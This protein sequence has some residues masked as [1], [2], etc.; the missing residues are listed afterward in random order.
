MK[1]NEAQKQI[2][3]GSLLGDAGIN[4]D[5]RYEGYEFAE[6]HS[7]KQ[8]NYLKWKNQ[9]LNFNFKTYEKHNLCTIR[10]SNKIFKDYKDLFYRNGSKIVTKEVLDKLTPLSIA[11]WHM[12]DGDY[13]YKTETIRLATHCF[14]LKGNKLIRNWFIKKWN[15]MPK[16]RRSYNEATKREYFLLEFTC[17]NAKKFIEL[18]EK[19][20]ISQM[21]YKIGLDEEKRKRAKEKK[22][23]YNKRWWENNE[24]KRVAYYQKW[25][26]LNYQQYLKNKRKP[27]KN[28][29]YG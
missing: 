14:K 11:V 7:L 27:I 4:K 24:N 18:I 29:L 26:K 17:K 13:N 20:I 28:Y 15:I 12:D 10:K 5:K 2:I 21:N 16:I 23:E 9:H 19:H 25:K 8:I 22:Q 3:L 1:F 6:R